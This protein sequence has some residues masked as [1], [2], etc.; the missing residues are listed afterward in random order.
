MADS[1]GGNACVALRGLRT[2]REASLCGALGQCHADWGARQGS[3]PTLGEVDTDVQQWE[4]LDPD[5]HQR[6]GRGLGFS[7]SMLSGP[8]QQ[9]RLLAGSLKAP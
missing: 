9:A 5:E 7:L 2:R 3:K 4:P 6:R 1:C 8:V